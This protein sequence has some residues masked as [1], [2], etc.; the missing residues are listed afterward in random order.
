MDVS[1][2][3]KNW[4]RHPVRTMTSDSDYY[5][6]LLVSPDAPAAVIQA[7]Y[8]TLLQRLRARPDA[9]AH[10]AQAALLTEAYE[11]LSN[12]D[13]RAA[14][15]LARD[16]AASPDDYAATAVLD[17]DAE[18]Y[19]AHRCLFCGTAHGIERALG[20]DDDCG[21]CGSPLFPAERHRLEYSGQRML[22]RIP[23][24]RDVDLLVSWPQSAPYAAQM[25]D[26]SLNGMQ[27]AVG[28][29]LQLNQIVKIDCETCYAVAR[30]AHCKRERTGTSAERWLIG[31]E[32]LTLRFRTARGSFVSAQV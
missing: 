1:I 32:F 25:R 29:P 27:I 6:I 19:A 22:K 4:P 24:R 15:D 7:S 9:D 11:V 2:Y 16:I 14:Y 13:R 30:V 18:R 26:L 21:T 8:R 3:N 12:P 5:R 20:R 31:V 23:K 28:A 17:P 10:L